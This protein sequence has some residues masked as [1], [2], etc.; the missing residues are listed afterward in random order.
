MSDLEP[1]PQYDGRLN[2]IALIRMSSVAPAGIVPIPALPE[3]VGLTS[4]D[5]NTTT[6]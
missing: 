4:A 6:V 1:H 2:D 5:N 3:A